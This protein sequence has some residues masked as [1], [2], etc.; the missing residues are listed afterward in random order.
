MYQPLEV[1]SSPTEHICA[2]LTSLQ[3]HGF[4]VAL[5]KILTMNG[6]IWKEVIVA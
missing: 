1:R 3:L 2:T 6:E 4:F 5:L